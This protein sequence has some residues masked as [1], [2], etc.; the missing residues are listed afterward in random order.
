MYRRFIIRF[1]FKKT[2]DILGG[3]IRAMLSGG[4]PLSEDTQYFMNACMCCPVVQGY[5][6]TETCG[7]GTICNCKLIKITVCLT[8]EFA[9]IKRVSH[10]GDFFLDRYKAT[11]NSLMYV[12]QV[13]FFNSFTK[14]RQVEGSSF[15]G[16]VTSSLNPCFLQQCGI[17]H[18]V[19]LEHQ[20]V[21]QKLNLQVGKKVSV[22]VNFVLTQIVSLTNFIQFEVFYY[23]QLK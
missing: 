22:P 1:I 19:V 3:N 15:L 2:K 13:G 7:G 5:G 4:A 21:V 18:V 11:H 12:C 23:F 8:R 10:Y 17:K 6:L 16:I 9:R 14:K 20:L